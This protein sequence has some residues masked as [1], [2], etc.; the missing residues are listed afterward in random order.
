VDHDDADEFCRRAGVRARQVVGE[1]AEV[2]AA[3]LDVEDVD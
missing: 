2:A 1:D 3:E